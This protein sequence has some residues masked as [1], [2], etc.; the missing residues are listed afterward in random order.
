MNFNG[1]NH[2][3]FYIG[4]VALSIMFV[5]TILI[6]LGLKFRSTGYKI[7][8]LLLSFGTSVL[9]YFCFRHEL[10]FTMIGSLFVIETGV[11]FWIALSRRR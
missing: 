7:V 8:V 11:G 10:N 5:T 6:L 3:D 4:A 2:L 1:L 9:A